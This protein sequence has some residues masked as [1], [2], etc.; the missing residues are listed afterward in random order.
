MDS[1]EGEEG[2]DVLCLEIRVLPPLK[3]TSDAEDERL[4][5]GGKRIGLKLLV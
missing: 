4:S 3:A 5:G 1:G 2:G